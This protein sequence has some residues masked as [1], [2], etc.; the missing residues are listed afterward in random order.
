VGRVLERF[1]TGDHDGFLLEPGEA[2]TGPWP[3]QLGFQ[4]VRHMTPG[5]DA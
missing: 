1:D 4:Q 3:G 2:G 5:H